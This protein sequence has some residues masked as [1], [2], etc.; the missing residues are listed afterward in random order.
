MQTV[1]PTVP[2]R[3]ART[4]ARRFGYLMA[5]AV[6][7][8]ML[9][10]FNNLLEWGFPDFLT[11]DFAKLLPIVNLSLVASIA[12]N[13]TYTAFDPKWYHSATQAL[14]AFIG[15]G[16]AVR[17]LQVFPF[18]FASYRGFPWETLVRVVVTITIVAT[19]IATVA[20]TIKA[21]AAFVKGD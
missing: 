11:E 6:N 19:G 18:D 9:Y 15:L 7:G 16:V 17:T 14:V 3:P 12:V 8:V 4:A 20:E 1:T 10:V 13:L 5:A 2:T 21:I